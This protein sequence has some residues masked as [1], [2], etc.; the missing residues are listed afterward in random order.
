MVS[1]FIV[2]G[3]RYTSVGHPLLLFC[4]TFWTFPFS[5]FISFLFFLVV[6]FIKSLDKYSLEY[7]LPW[8]CCDLGF[9]IFN[10]SSISFLSSVNS[11][12]I[13]SC[14]YP[15]LLSIFRIPIQIILKSFPKW[16]VRIFN[17]VWCIVLQFFEVFGFVERIFISWKAL[18][19]FYCFFIIVMYG[20]SLLFSIPISLISKHAH[21]F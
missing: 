5:F 9:V 8:T 10:V 19:H 15:F 2:K 4:F 1:S 17:S 7:I 13:S 16:C 6:S 3:T 14:F 11:H 20:Y 21:L 18:I 12:F